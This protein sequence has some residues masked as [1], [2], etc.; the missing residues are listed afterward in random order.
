MTYDVRAMQARLVSMGF[1]PGPVDGAWGPR[2]RAAVIEFQLANGLKPDGI[3]GPATRGVLFGPAARPP[4]PAESVPLDMPWLVE[5]ERLR[6]TREAPGAPSSP[7]I[8]DWADDLGIAY[9]NDGVPWCG[10]FVAH[11][12]RTGLPNDPIPS[13]P[14]GAR[15]W[16]TYGQSCSPQFGATLVFWRGSKAGWQGHVGFYWAEDDT[17]F[18]VLGGNQSDSVSV[19]RI[20][21]T[22]LLWA[23]WTAYATPLG[24]TRRASPGGVLLSTNEA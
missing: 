16:L 3:V 2:T 22:R 4:K 8:M 17:A 23:R 15:N 12:I 14:L 11:C 6:G 7:I 5:A 9:P 20:A 1:D 19:T 24:I 21:K 10:L 13:N 18:H